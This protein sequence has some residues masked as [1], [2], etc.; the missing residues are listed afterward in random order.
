MFHFSLG[1][2]SSIRFDLSPLSELLTYATPFSTKIL[3]FCHLF[4]CKK[5]MMKKK[6]MIY[7]MNNKI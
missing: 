4:I 6:D 7:D 2:E 5:K 3:N 1:G